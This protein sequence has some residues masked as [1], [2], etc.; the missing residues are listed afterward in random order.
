MALDPKSPRYQFD[1]RQSYFAGLDVREA[2]GRTLEVRS[3][4]TKVGIV[5]P[6]LIYL[7][8]DFKLVGAELDHTKW[9]RQIGPRGQLYINLNASVP[10][11]A[12]Y[13]I[14]YTEA[15]NQH[16]AIVFHQA[17]EVSDFLGRSCIFS[18]RTG[19]VGCNTTDKHVYLPATEFVAS[20]A[21]TGILRF[22]LL[23]S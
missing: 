12:S 7:D 13:L 6:N 3:M 5:I 21:E 14:A 18:S 8:A 19:D 22:A 2:A 20:A 9:A 17:P 16:E 15:D 10:G 4:L 11:S 23:Q 1:D